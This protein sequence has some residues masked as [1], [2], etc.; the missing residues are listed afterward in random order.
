MAWLPLIP[1]DKRKDW[2]ERADRR[3]DFLKR[4]SERWRPEDDTSATPSNDIRLS[5]ANALTQAAELALASDQTQRGQELMEDALRYLVEGTEDSWPI[6]RTALLG[7]LLSEVSTS[8]SPSGVTLKGAGRMRNASWNGPARMWERS[9]GPLIASAVAYGP[10]DSAF[11]LLQGQLP[12]EDFHQNRL[13][14]LVF[15]NALETDTLP[16]FGFWRRSDGGLE[17][18]KSD[19]SGPRPSHF[20]RSAFVA[21][22]QR[23][24]AQLRLLASD[25]AHWRDE[26]R[27]RAPLIDWALLALYVASFRHGSDLNPDKLAEISKETPI[28]GVVNFLLS[29]ARELK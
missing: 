11:P 24:A 20:A 6:V 2:R 15:A 21:L 27:P 16:A 12:S 7:A 28:G 22:H 10:L 23:Y 1:D 13:A 14:F 18:P 17:R 4:F 29:V 3:I 25:T 8:L 5:S 19:S 26:L 9:A